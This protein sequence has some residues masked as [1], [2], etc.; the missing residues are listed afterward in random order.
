[1]SH[2]PDRATLRILTMPQSPPP[3]VCDGTYTCECQ[4]CIAD[5]AK[6]VKLGVRRTPARQHRRR[7]A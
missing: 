5:R 1:M 6:L 4:Q 7:A 3:A 2:R